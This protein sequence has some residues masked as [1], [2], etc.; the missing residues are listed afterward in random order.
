MAVKRMY[1]DDLDGSADYS[2]A[3]RT[4]QIGSHKYVIDLSDSNYTSVLQAIEFADL[5]DT[6]KKVGKRLQN[7][8]ESTQLFYSLTV[9]QKR[10]LKADLGLPKAMRPRN[11]VVAKW[12]ALQ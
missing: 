8:P 6:V 3:R 1:V 12:L 11:D 7:Q 2:V 4:I 9:E 5:L 10:K